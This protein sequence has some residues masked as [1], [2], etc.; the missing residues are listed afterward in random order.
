MGWTHP[1]YE[2]QRGLGQPSL[3]VTAM[4]EIIRGIRERRLALGQ[5][6]SDVWYRADGSTTFNP[7]ME[8]LDGM[9]MNGTASYFWWNMVRIH[10]GI[11]AL[12]DEF[13]IAPGRGTTYTAST[14]RELVGLPAL[15]PQAL[16]KWSDPRWWQGW[17]DALDLLI[18]GWQTNPGHTVSGIKRLGSQKSTLDLAWQDP[19]VFSTTEYPVGQYNWLGTI[20]LPK[21]TGLNCAWVIDQPLR[22]QAIIQRVGIYTLN[23]TI[24]GSLSEVWL[25][26]G[27]LD[28]AKMTYWGYVDDPLQ[29]KC[30]TAGGNFTMYGTD[31]GPGGSTHTEDFL[32]EL[33]ADDFP[34]DEAGAITL[35]I[36]NTPPLLSPFAG[37]SPGTGAG[38]A[39]F[40]GNVTYYV[41]IS[42]ELTDQA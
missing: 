33:D 19:F 13:T 4:F 8:D 2:D 17:Q 12:A 32:I 41:D 40:F 39:A 21:N 28:E 1:T 24:A 9:Q 7:T 10:G 18:Y 42:S 3:Y 38:W 16:D 14:L 37:T 22:F 20:G 6:P 11:G 36:V 34:L 5:T 29:V 30:T 35:E 31:V 27:P 25:D 26:N 23:P 15:H